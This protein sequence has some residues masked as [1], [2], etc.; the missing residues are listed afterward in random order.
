MHIADVTHYVQEGSP[1]DMEAQ[2]RSTTVYLVDR[3]LDM[4]PELLS[5]NLCSLRGNV[6][7]CAVSV[8]WNLEHKDDI[9]WV[10][11]ETWFGRTLLRSAW[12][13][14]YQTAQSIIN[15]ESKG[16]Y[17]EEAQ[18]VFGKQPG[19]VSAVRD[20]LKLMMTIAMDVRRQRKERGA[21]ELHSAEVDF[22][23]TRS[24]IQSTDNSDG[25]AGTPQTEG[26]T[27]QTVTATAVTPHQHLPVMEMIE[28]YMIMANSAVAKQIYTFCPHQACLR[29]HPLPRSDRFDELI[30]T[31]AVKGIT[32]DAS[33][34]A[35]L[36][37]EFDSNWLQ[38]LCSFAII[39]CHQKHML[40]Q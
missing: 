7:R 5:T 25:P 23:L 9:G 24:V 31:A 34:N 38:R 30:K 32:L 27:K 18:R 39:R 16:L 20:M 28:E 12:E 14:S 3:R 13:G 22:D 6:D 21:L 8:I 11:T 40:F 26:V 37:G 17:A 29:R 33:S 36:A 10:P 19:G 1:L 2:S 35:A 4:L 15:G